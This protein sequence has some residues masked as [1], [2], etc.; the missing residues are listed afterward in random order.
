MNRDRDGAGIECRAV[1]KDFVPDWRGRRQRALADVTLDFPR[2]QITALAGPNG[3]GKSTLLKLCAGLTRPTG[4]SCLVGGRDA[5]ARADSLQLGYLAERVV[6]PGRCSGR[7]LLEQLA[8]ISGVERAAARDEAERA[9][10]R[11]GL[12]ATGEQRVGGYSK[13]QQQRLALAQALLGAPDLLLLDEPAAGLDPHG[14][15]LL[16]R[17]LAEERTRG[18]TVVVTTHFLA[19]V[20]TQADRCVL[21]DRGRVRFA[22]PAAEAAARGGLERI[23]R[24]E[25]PA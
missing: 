24:E 20:E 15:V 1:T 7:A 11:T 22:G 10:D 17:I 2:G 9:L 16:A 12:R 25:I 6:W 4:G 23:Y 5:A 14:V 21:L 8:L 13:G 3:S 19:A 18:A